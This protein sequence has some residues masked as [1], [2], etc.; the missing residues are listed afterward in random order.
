MVTKRVA[1]V[2]EG[3]MGPVHPCWVTDPLGAVG[4]MDLRDSL[5]SEPLCFMIPSVCPSYSMAQ[6]LTPCSWVLIS[7]PFSRCPDTLSRGR[8]A[9]LPHDCASRFGYRVQSPQPQT[10]PFCCRPRGGRSG[11]SLFPKMGTGIRAGE[12]VLELRRVLKAGPLDGRTGFWRGPV[13]T[14]SHFSQQGL[15]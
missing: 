4:T 5:S 13:C 7:P 8:P 6:V 12:L 3:L 10:P 1:R 15:C 2:P 11:G 9:L 14:C